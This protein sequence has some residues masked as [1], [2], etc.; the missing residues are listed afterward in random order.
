MIGVAVRHGRTKSDAQ[1][2]A[3]HLLKETSAPVELLNS[4]ASDL[5]EIM[6]DMFIARD[7]SRADAA[8]LHFFISPARDMSN[9]ELRAQPKIKL[10]DFMSL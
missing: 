8:F 4:G 9:D 3:S 5:H 10:S 6:S 7:G 1:N 2:L